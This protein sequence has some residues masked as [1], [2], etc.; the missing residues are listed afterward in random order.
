MDAATQPVFCSI[1][2]GRWL[3]EAFGRQSGEGSV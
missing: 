2:T 1:V 3:Y